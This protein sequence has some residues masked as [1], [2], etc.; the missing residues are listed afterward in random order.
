MKKILVTL[1]SLLFVCIGA[2]LLYAPTQGCTPGYWKN[3]IE[4]WQDY[5]P[6]QT[7]ESAFDPAQTWWQFLPPDVANLRFYTLMEALEFQG[8]PGITGAARI[9]IRQLTAGLL[10]AAHDEV[11]YWAMEN[12]L[13]LAKIA[14]EDVDR[15]NYLWW[16]GNFTYWNELGCSID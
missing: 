14:L 16:A 5:V 3:H 11:S 13:A 2:G 1:F 8:G 7:L 4:N 12:L 15:D 10:N 9:L 6:G